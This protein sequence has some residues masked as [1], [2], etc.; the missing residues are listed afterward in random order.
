[1]L[2]NK[3]IEFNGDF[4]HMNPKKYSATDELKAFNREHYRSGIGNTAADIWK[5]DEMKLNGYKQLG[6][7]VKVVWESE[8]HENPEKIIQECIDFLK[9]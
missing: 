2:G 9:K 1:M 5:Y 3:I 4:W 6:Y 7:D 8:Y